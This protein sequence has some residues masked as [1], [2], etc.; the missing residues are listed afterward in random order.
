MKF[1]SKKVM[2]R[3]SVVAGLLVIAFIAVI[4][5]AVLI[6]TVEK[7]Y[8]TEVQKRYERTNDTIPAARG[9]ILADDG[10]LLAASIP[11]YRLFI[12]FMSWEKDSLRRA[13]DQHRRDSLLEDKI[14]S[15]CL[16]MKEI[17][18]EVNPEKLKR[19]LR[20]GRRK[21][22]HHWKLLNRRVSYIEYRQVEKLPFFNLGKYRS[23][24]HT[25]QFRT[26]KK[27][28]GDLAART[29]GDL[30]K[31]NG[32]PRSG[33]EL[34][35]DTILSGKPGLSRRQ[36]VLS[37]Y[38]TIIETPPV[39]GLDV[40]TT[41][42]V[43][44]QDICEIA[45]SEKLAEIEANA[46]VCILMEVATGDIK[47]IS[48]LTRTSSGNYREINPIAINNMMEPGSVFKPMS[49]L[50]ALN[51]GVITLDDEVDT[52][53][54]IV[55]MYGQRMRDHNWHR[56]GYGVLN[57]KQI[58]GNSSNIGV[59]QL[60]DAHYKHDPQKFVDGIYSTGIA[61]DLK[62]PIPGYAKPNIPSPKSRGENWAKTDLPWMSIGYVTQIPPIST[63]TF[64][65]GIANNGRMMRPRFVK[66]ILRDGQVVR[67]CPPVAVR[68]Q[69]A[70]PEAVRD[71]RT[72]LEYVI[73]DGVGK[74]A[75]SKQFK[76][77][78]KTGTAQ[79]WTNTGFSH[80]YLVSF[81]G[82][83]PADKPKYSCIVCIRKHGQAS[84]GTHCGPVFRRVAETVMSAQ[85]ISDY[86]MAR[87][88][89]YVETPLVKPGNLNA[90]QETL[91][92]LGVS[93]DAGWLPA[94]PLR[95]GYA[96][97]GDRLSLRGVE[98]TTDA[99]PD[100]RGYGLRDA[101]ERLERLDLRVKAEGAGHVVSQSIA[102]GKPFSAGDS[103]RLVLKCAKKP[104][105]PKRIREIPAKSPME[106]QDSAMAKPT[107]SLKTPLPA[108][109]AH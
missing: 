59:S 101:V 15:I 74:K 80:E 35:L 48:S 4:V 83:F 53:C 89:V 94:T 58:I 56:G 109:A 95:W 99:V 2:Y 107:D 33:L 82:Y 67:E 69:M 91:G 75:G 32:K 24:F 108:T 60:I 18:P 23:G 1:D 62:L 49:F 65:N 57:A 93:Y 96:E 17:F 10:Q 103:V 12:D 51:D 79:V 87:D 70:R 54:G 28:F 3:Y 36:K 72:C 19:H 44:M 97:T 61:E 25:E 47:G 98:E 45:L 31:D 76:V 46:G 5:K 85:N 41:I 14:D 55:P 84:G 43:P 100:V 64:Y 73:S 8:W 21:K 52:G 30:Y 29:I 71:I 40:Q 77:A 20:E 81:V 88:T 39:D 22:S 105:A 78:G 104:S 27:P 38:L 34:G 7:D 6:M 102:P 42:S 37:R 63:L 16:G 13:K 50:V 9:N 92:A 86:S 11:E 26:R 66:N 106:P 68:E 90:M